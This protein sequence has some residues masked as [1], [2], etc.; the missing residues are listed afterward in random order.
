MDI[1]TNRDVGGQRED[2]LLTTLEQLLELPATDVNLTLKQAAQLLAE[3]LGA[4]K[5]DI[6]FHEK[7]NDTIVALGTSDT[8]MGRKQHAIG[9]DRLPLANGG[10]TV[11]VFLSGKS[12]ITGHA[13][14][15][16]DELV[17]IKVGLGVKSQIATVF[18]VHTKHRGIL[19]AASATP[20]FFVEQ[21][22][23]FLESVAR[24]LGIVLERAELTEQ[25]R[26]EAVE[27]GQRLAA[28]ELLT[29]VAHDLRNYLTPMKG[30]MEMLERRARREE[31]TEDVR[32]TKA[33]IH[34]LGMLERVIGDL[35]DVARLNQGI[36]IITPFP[37]NL[38]ALVQEVVVAFHSDEH[39]IQ[40]HS[41]AEVV[42]SADA[43]R[44]RQLLENVLANAVKYS[45]LRSP[46]IVEIGIE[47]RDDGAWV[48][49]T[50]T[51]VGPGLSAEQLTTFLRPFAAGSQSTGL[52]LGL[53][54]AN[55]I[56]EA[57]Q[58]TLTLESPGGQGMQI[59]LALPVEEDDLEVQE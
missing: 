45:P 3:V 58:G 53:Y 22:L 1:N 31:R 43:A 29:I 27:K 51:N 52:G 13:E 20:D 18:Q 11:E 6:F 46:I 40:V 23:R 10:C 9:M 49:L 16:P 17:G 30:R 32:D 12:Y 7:A 2:R 21:D 39:P 57:H 15:D 35:L 55:K 47:N 8:P 41:P 5:V 56:A 26:Q 14:Q 48:V 50:V 24:W 42:L 4:D 25:M 19:L 33:T 59:R 54:L 38:V 44:L 37:M 36:Y 28:E 34:T